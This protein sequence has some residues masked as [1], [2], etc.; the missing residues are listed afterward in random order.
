MPGD[1]SFA[2]ANAPLRKPD[3]SCPRM[4]CLATD[5]IIH[6]GRRSVTAGKQTMRH[7]TDT[8][9]V[10]VLPPLL[11]GGALA[12]GLLLHWVFPVPVINLW[13]ARVLGAVLLLASG[14]LAFAAERVMHRAG[15]NVRP[16]RPT[17]TIVSNGPF[18]FTR[19]PLYLA[20]I[21]LYVGVTLLFN[22][23]WPLALLIPVVVVLRFG[24]VAREERYLEAKFGGAYLAY[25][26]RVRRWL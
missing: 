23:L 9:N 16:D 11:F 15:T 20:L 4:R 5:A 22:A 8:P 19:N 12:L 14:G 2:L 26:A 18:R 3:L 13:G 17:L 1:H 24:V 21:G 7:S 25:K 6:L 10:L